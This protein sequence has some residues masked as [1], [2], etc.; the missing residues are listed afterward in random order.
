M[1]CFNFFISVNFHL[2]IVCANEFKAK[3]KQKLTEIKN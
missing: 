2:S 3:G 1:C